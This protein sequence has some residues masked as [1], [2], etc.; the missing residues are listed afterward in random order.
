MRNHGKD[1]CPILPQFCA[2]GWAVP[3]LAAKS[4]RL[5]WRR[6]HCSAE[7]SSDLQFSQS[8]SSVILS[9]VRD[10]RSESRTQSKDPYNLHRTTGMHV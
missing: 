5:T 4:A 3:T 9:E 10:T 2:G 8:R 6:S 7:Q 1:G